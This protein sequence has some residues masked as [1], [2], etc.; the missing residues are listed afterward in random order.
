MGFLP[1]DIL[2]GELANM[3]TVNGMRKRDDEFVQVCTAWHDSASPSLGDTMSVIL[4]VLFDESDKF[5]TSATTTI[6]KI[7]S[8]VKIQISITPKFPCAPLLSSLPLLW[9]TTDLLSVIHPGCGVS[10]SF[11]LLLLSSSTPLYGY[12]TICLSIYL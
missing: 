9:A 5:Y 10:S 3:R 1:H 2:V 4:G 6:I 7:K 12:T 8:R 11:L